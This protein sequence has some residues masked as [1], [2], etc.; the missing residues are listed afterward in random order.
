MQI[1]SLTNNFTSSVMNQHKTDAEQTL[2]KIGATRELS[3]QDG[4]TMINAN[5]LNSQIAT[6]TQQVQ[7]ENTR[8]GMLQIADGA[9]Q[10]VQ[11]GTERLNELSV[12]YNNAALNSDQRAMISEEFNATRDA[13]SEMVA[14]T[15]YNGQSL[16]GSDSPL[17]LSDVELTSVSIDSTE[18]IESLRENV[19]S[20]FSDVGSAT[21]EAQVSVNN[22]LAGITSTTS[23][24]AQMSE[25]PMSQNINQLN[26]STLGL[27]AATMAQSHNTAILQQQMAAL[28]KF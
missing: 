2:A 24:Y 11:Q 22:L 9:L 15:S 7:N 4:A 26:Q 14:Q 28:L 16:F 6:M 21:Q 3:G 18:S 10:G 12:S 1:G 27:T 5:Q 23:S 19:N 17:G 25:T 13:M 8:V 20:L